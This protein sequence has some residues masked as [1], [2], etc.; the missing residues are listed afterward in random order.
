[1]VEAGPHAVG[2]A[3]A[4]P[5]KDKDASAKTHPPQTVRAGKRIIKIRGSCGLLVATEDRQ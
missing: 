5:D 1:V 4:P 3:A 2:A